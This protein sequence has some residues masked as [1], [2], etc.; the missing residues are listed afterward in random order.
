M[1]R[2]GGALSRNPNMCASCSSLADGR[3][4]A[5]LS[6]VTLPSGSEPPVLEEMENEHGL[7]THH[8][9]FELTAHGIT[10]GAP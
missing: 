9:A 6:I 7:T 10:S 5:S 3:Q 8:Q 4:D 2:G 1:S